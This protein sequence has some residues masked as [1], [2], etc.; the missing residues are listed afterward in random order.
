VIITRI[1]LGSGSFRL[2]DELRVTVNKCEE[3][4]IHIELLGD[5]AMTDSI[6]R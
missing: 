3:V 6:Q 4:S 2:M 5:K 1:D